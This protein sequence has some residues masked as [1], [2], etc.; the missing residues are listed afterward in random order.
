MGRFETVVDFYRYR[1]PYPPEFFAAVAARVGL[2]HRTRVLDVGCGPGNLAIGFA[3]LT[4]SCTAIDVEPEM[5]RVARA[6]AAEAKVE[7]TF[8][9]KAIEDLDFADNSFNCAFHLS[10]RS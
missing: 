1:E 8:I 4:G 7:I 9:E 10:S 2:T 6:A 5:L 3:P